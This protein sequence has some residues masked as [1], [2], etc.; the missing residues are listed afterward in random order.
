VQKKTPRDFKN[1]KKKKKK[2]KKKKNGEAWSIV[3][4]QFD[5]RHE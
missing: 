2:K 3:C 4:S 5:A 1:Q